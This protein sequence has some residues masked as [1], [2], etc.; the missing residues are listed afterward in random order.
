MGEGWR[1]KL[2]EQRERWLGA[3]GRSL[4]GGLLGGCALFL[5]AWLATADLDSPAGAHVPTAA[6]LSAST[7]GTGTGTGVATTGTTTTATAPTPPPAP[8][9]P[10]HWITSWGAAT[11]GPSPAAPL[12][13]RG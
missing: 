5:G 1:R 10:S 4:L 11:Q 6:A 2:T 13:E 8:S 3:G 12:S 7:T 9:G